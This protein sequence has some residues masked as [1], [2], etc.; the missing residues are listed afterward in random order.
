MKKYS[1]HCSHPQSAHHSISRRT[2]LKLK[3][4]WRG[5]PSCAGSGRMSPWDKSFHSSELSSTLVQDRLLFLLFSSFFLFD[6]IVVIIYILTNPLHLQ[7]MQTGKTHERHT[8]LQNVIWRKSTCIRE[9]KILVSKLKTTNTIFLIL[10]LFTFRKKHKTTN[11]GNSEKSFV[12]K[13]YG[14]PYARVG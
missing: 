2:S 9:I 14:T 13:G 1:P 10:L 8:Y 3:D 12:Y 7:N 4:R 5:L 11:K 6:K